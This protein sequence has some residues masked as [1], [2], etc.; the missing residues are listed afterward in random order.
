[1]HHHN[2]HLITKRAITFGRS[3]LH[4][5]QKTQEMLISHH[6]DMT[7]KNVHG[8]NDPAKKKNIILV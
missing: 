5:M 7:K 1:M 6:V 2:Q 4:Y 8:R 3:G